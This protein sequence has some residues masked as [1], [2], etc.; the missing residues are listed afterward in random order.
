MVR[1]FLVADDVIRA[2]ACIGG[3]YDWLR[4]DSRKPLTSWPVRALL[5]IVSATDAAWVKRAAHLMGY[6]GGYGYGYG[7][8]Y[9]YGYGDGY[10]DG[11]GGGGGDGGV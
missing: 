10:G 5:K 8:G 6:G 9:G 2:G 3:V 4:D 1:R 7:D 11:D